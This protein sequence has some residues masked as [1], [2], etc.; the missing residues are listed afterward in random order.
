MGVYL[1][2]QRFIESD[3]QYRFF[4]YNWFGK[5]GAS[6]GEVREDHIRPG[7]FVIT[8]DERLSL[9]EQTETLMHEFLHLSDFDMSEEEVL[10]LTPII[11][12]NQPV[13]VKHLRNELIRTRNFYD[14]F[15]LAQRLKC[16]PEDLKLYDVNVGCTDWR[17][18]KVKDIQLLLLT[19]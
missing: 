11:Y 4:F 12:R 2:L 17:K 14:K 6:L 19:F 3:G 1:G 8:I 5:L 13:L 15:E 9:E 10:G 7:R 16:K 18:N